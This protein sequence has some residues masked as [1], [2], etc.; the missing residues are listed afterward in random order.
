VIPLRTFAV[1]VGLCLATT[2]AQAQGRAARLGVPLEGTAGPLNA[3]TDVPD[4]AVGHTTLI[5]GAGR[6]R[7]GAGPVRTGVTAVFPRGSN[8]LTPVFAGWFSG[9]HAQ[10]REDRSSLRGHGAGD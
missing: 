2:A 1:A 4:V 7:I 5:R 10:R 9:A 3:I 6:L 8:D